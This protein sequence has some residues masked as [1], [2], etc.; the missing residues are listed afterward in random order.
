MNNQVITAVYRHPDAHK[1]I[2]CPPAGVIYPEK[3]VTMGDPKAGPP[4]WHEDS[5]KRPWENGR[6]LP[7][8]TISGRQLGEASRRLVV[9]SLQLR[10][11]R[12]GFSNQPRGPPL[13]SHQNNRYHDNERNRVVPPRTGYHP[14]TSNGHHWPP[15]PSPVRNQVDQTYHRPRASLVSHDAYSGYHSWHEKNNRRPTDQNRDYSPGF[16][17]YGRNR[18]PRQGPPHVGVQHPVPSRPQFQEQGGYSQRFQQYDGNSYPGQGPP[19]R[20]VQTPI[21]NRAQF[22][23]QGGYNNCGSY[24]QYGAPNYHSYR[25][26]ATWVPRVNP[27]SGREGYIHPQ[28]VDAQFSALDQGASRNP[29]PPRYS[30]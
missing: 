12:N 16:Q 13:S 6:H 23:Q 22:H 3:T 27:S 10:T 28:Q 25:A 26:S 8:G 11:D 20:G 19:L 1:H 18:Y 21:P 24:Q 29:P 2:A 9:N 17:Q 14:Q 4:L 30:R 7:N 15:N 5:G